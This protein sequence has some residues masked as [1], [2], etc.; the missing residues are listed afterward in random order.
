MISSMKRTWTWIGAASLAMFAFGCSLGAEAGAEAESVADEVTGTSADSILSGCTMAN[1]I[2]LVAGS[3][4]DRIKSCDNSHTL[5]MQTDGNL[6][7][8]DTAGDAVWTANTAGSGANVAVMQS[9][10]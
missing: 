9:D 2:S 4:N 7:V 10:G 5:V 3:T 8:Y 6:V 1:N